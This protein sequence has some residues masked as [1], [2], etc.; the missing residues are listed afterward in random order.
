MATRMVA[1][2]AVS[3]LGWALGLLASAVLLGGTVEVP[4]GISWT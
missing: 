1:A 4:S 3:G 2:M